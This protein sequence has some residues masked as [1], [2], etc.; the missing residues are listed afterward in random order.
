MKSSNECI[1]RDRDVGRE[2]E[3]VKK[4]KYFEECWVL[5]QGVEYW[6]LKN[7]LKPHIYPAI[8]GFHEQ[9]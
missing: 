7:E 4:E 2:R 5:S 1:E 3:G 9:N 6:H 8:R